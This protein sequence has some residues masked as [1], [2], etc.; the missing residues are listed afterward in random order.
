[1]YNAK[2]F[3]K[4]DCYSEK[5]KV[6]SVEDHRFSK[7]YD[8]VLQDNLPFEIEVDGD[9]LKNASTTS[10]DAFS[11]FHFRIVTSQFSQRKTGRSRSR[12]Q[13]SQNAGDVIPCSAPPDEPYSLR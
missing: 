5:V 7:G 11:I 12:F 1:M 6:I 4:K 3:I 9:S 10:G 13:F 2:T 8:V